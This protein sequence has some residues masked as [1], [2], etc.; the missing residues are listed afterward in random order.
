MRSFPYYQP[1]IAAAT[2]LVKQADSIRELDKLVKKEG[3]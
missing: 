2:E 3:K 1:A